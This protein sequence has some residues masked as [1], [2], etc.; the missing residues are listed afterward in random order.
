MARMSETWGLD[1]AKSDPRRCF[2]TTLRQRVW[3]S[4]PSPRYQKQSIGD[5]PAGGSRR[6]FASAPSL[7]AYGGEYGYGG[8]KGSSGASAGYRP[9]DGGGGSVRCASAHANGRLGA[10]SG[11]I[12]VGLDLSSV[13][14]G[15][16]RDVVCVTHPELTARVEQHGDTN[17]VDDGLADVRRLPPVSE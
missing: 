8:V 12:Q 5:A 10:R 2:T 17:G 16:C 1:Q 4:S 14:S 15:L 6:A 7:C 13:G 11:L 9:C 3:F